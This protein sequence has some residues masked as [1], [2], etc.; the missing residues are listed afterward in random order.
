MPKFEGRCTCTL[1]F[2]LIR[3]YAF[4]FLSNISNFFEIVGIAEL[5]FKELNQIVE[6][7]ELYLNMP[8]AVKNAETV[9]QQEHYKKAKVDNQMRKAISDPTQ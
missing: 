5:P 9:Q 1:K 7:F 3:P 4:Q 8:I 2:F 6:H